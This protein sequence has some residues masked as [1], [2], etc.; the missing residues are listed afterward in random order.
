MIL[1]KLLYRQNVTCC[2]MALR[3]IQPLEEKHWNALVDDL[4]K[5]QTKEQAD[6]LKEAIENKNKF[7]ITE[8]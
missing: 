4:E 1:G 3:E 6:F 5:G 8:Y 2:Y 7:E